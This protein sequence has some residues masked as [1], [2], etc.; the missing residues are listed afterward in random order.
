MDVAPARRR[1]RLVPAV[2]V[3]GRVGRDL[4]RVDRPA[5]LRPVD[6][7]R[8]HRRLLPAVPDPVGAADLAA[9][10]DHA[11]GHPAF[12][13]AVRRGAVPALPHD[14]GALRRAHGAAHRAVPGD[15]PADVRVRP[16][17]RRVAVPG[18]RAGHLRAHLAWSLVVG[19]AGGSGG[20]AGTAGGHRAVPC[21]GLAALP[22]ARPRSARVP[23]AGAAAR[24]RARVLRLPVL[25]Y[26]RSAR[27][28]PRPGAWLGPWRVGAAGGG[29][30]GVLG[31][32]PRRPAAL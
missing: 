28:L 2:P 11:V 31:R 25:A 7:P 10:A 13:G 18:L 23:A 8:L 4:V 22:G 12:L 14:P 6:R 15:L 9:R 3:A 20:C 30:E 17:L 26:R 21:A 32:D 29:G 24:R 27:A 16:A 19:I 5:R 1:V